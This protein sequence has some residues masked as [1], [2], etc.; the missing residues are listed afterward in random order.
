MKI[1]H[2]TSAHPRDDIRV[3]VKMARCL[4]AEGL[5]VSLSV[6]DGRGDAL[7]DGVRILDSGKPQG[8]FDR[9]NRARRA[10][11]RRA[12]ETDADIYHLHDP[13]LLPSALELARRGKRVIFDAHED[14]PAAMMS[15][16]YL[17]RPLRST[18]AFG[19]DRLERYVARRIS[20]VVA[21]T[22]HIRDKFR[23]MGCDSTAINNYPLLEEIAAE[24]GSMA[25]VPGQFCYVGA[26]SA[27]RGL[28]PLVE[29]LQAVPEPVRLKLVGKFSEAETQRIASQ[30]PGWSRVDASGP[31]PRAQAQRVLAE[32]VAGIVTFLP[33]P[34]HVRA[35]PN[36]MF[37]YMGAGLPVIASHFAPWREII[38]G[39]GC[40]LCV[41]PTNS[42]D[43]ANAISYI[44]THADEA[45][46]MG[47]R[48]RKAVLSRYNWQ[49]ELNNLMNVYDNVLVDATTVR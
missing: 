18:V 23:A 39:V 20:H 13:E 37:E 36:K 27:A 29:A 49:S 35:Q 22:P 44:A 47:E 33:E 11:S 7:V 34:N 15:K 14:H 45:S 17:P 40:G 24:R 19:I 1:T 8:R 38:E 31:I 41:D 5:D 12:L 16:H 32:S 30:M 9:M 4:A 26:V 46:E 10:V 42:S 21:A 3:F 48:G 2:I 6:A 28:L 43:I 25:R